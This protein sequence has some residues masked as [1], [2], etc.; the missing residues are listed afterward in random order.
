MNNG[1]LCIIICNILRTCLIK[2]QL[3][4]ARQYILDIKFIKLI[5]IPYD[6]II[7]IFYIHDKILSTPIY[8]YSLIKGVGTKTQSEYW[9]K[10]PV[11]E[12]VK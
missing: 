5:L 11:R 9:Y 7:V 2:S 8:I 1:Y 4:R 12:L 3:K 10:N 6:I